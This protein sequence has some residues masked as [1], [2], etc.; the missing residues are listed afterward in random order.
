MLIYYNSLNN[1]I[2][3]ELI[4][5]ASEL[6]LSEF[7]QAVIRSL[8]SHHAKDFSIDDISSDVDEQIIG[9]Y[10]LDAIRRSLRKLVVAGYLEGPK[11]DPYYGRGYYAADVY[12]LK[13]RLPSVPMRRLKKKVETVSGQVEMDEAKE[14]LLYHRKLGPYVTIWIEETDDDPDWVLRHKQYALRFDNETAAGDAYS[15]TVA[16][17]NN[18]SA[19]ENFAKGLTVKQ[20]FTKY[21]SDEYGIDNGKKIFDTDVGVLVGPK[22]IRSSR[23][24]E[25]SKL[26]KSVSYV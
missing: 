5:L 3:C 11:H 15:G 17:G 4:D 9:V 23:T 12:T 14:S 22:T 20:I 24:L 10:D 6:K 19:L 26:P 1:Y 2:A 16:V 25:K 7:D 13:K 21:V 8:K 18:I